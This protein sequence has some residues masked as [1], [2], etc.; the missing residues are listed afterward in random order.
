MVAVA[1]TTY[2]IAIYGWDGADGNIRLAIRA[3]QDAEPN[4]AALVRS[5]FWDVDGTVHAMLVTNG[6][7][8]VGGEFSYAAPRTGKAYATD[9]FTGEPDTS[10]PMVY[11]SRVETIVEDGEG[12][13]FMAGNFYRVGQTAVTNLVHIL[14]DGTVDHMFRPDPDNTVRALLLEGDTL[15]FAGDFLSTYGVV[16]RRAA[17]VRVTTGELLPWDPQANRPIYALALGADAIY[18]GGEFQWI[19][20]Q[21]RD[22]VAALDVGTGQPLPWNPGA[23]GTVLALLVDYGRV[24]VGGTFTML[25]GQQRT[26]L[27]AVEADTGQVTSWAPE[28]DGTR[29]NVLAGHCGT[30]FTGG[31][32]SRIFG[33]ARTGL[34]AVNID[35]F[36]PANWVP[37]ISE[38]NRKGHRSN[39]RALAIS[40]M[41]LV[42][43]GEFLTS[44]LTQADLVAL[45]TGSGRPP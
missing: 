8:Y 45:D 34:A 14:S 44:D 23:D 25:G 24:V 12:G 27:G 10:F 43:G 20:G 39:V 11:G 41:R 22:H 33:Q 19:G 30:V 4:P 1:G 26:H 35:T 17:A 18:A 15:Y 5:D 6:T 31:D 9:L 16:R 36:E 28:P 32:F 29:V 38:A 37:P 40:G 21:A 3:G 13:W 42:V 7:V 2:Y